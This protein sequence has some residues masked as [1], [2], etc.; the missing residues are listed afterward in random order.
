MERL[1]QFFQRRDEL[2][3]GGN[4]ILVPILCLSILIQNILPL[5]TSQISPFP[6][7]PML[8]NQSGCI[9][10]AYCVSIAVQFYQKGLLNSA[11][12]VPISHYTFWTVHK[13]VKAIE[14]SVETSFFHNPTRKLQQWINAVCRGHG[15][16]VIAECSPEWTIDFFLVWHDLTYSK[17]D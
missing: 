16:S 4:T 11:G 1:F 14:V 12:L 17:W 8:H 5:N 9:I 7:Q 15:G 10:L 6:L 13:M 2:F 3:E